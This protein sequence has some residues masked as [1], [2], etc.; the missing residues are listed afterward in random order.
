M[1]EEE[2]T[3]AG[4]GSSGTEGGTGTTETQKEPGEEEGGGGGPSG[5]G[6]YKHDRKHTASKKQ[7]TH[8]VFVGL[9]EQGEAYCDSRPG[10]QRA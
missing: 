6:E 1:T 8:L 2:T 4:A 3:P 9:H 10:R 5:A 7:N